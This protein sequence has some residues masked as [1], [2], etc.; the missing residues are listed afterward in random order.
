MAKRSNGEGSIYRRQDGRWCGS[1]YIETIDGVKR[2]YVYASTQKLVKQKLKELESNQEKCWEKVLLFQDWMMQWMESYKKPML[3]QTTYDN[4]MM[5]I[6]KHINGQSLGK[7]ELDKLTTDALQKFYNSKLVGDENGSKLSPRTI[8]YIHTIIGSSLKQAYKNELISKNVNDFT[9]LPR[10]EQ[11]EIEPLSI[12]EVRKLIEYVKDKEMYA[13]I[14]LEIYTGMRKGEI[15]SLQWKNVDFANKVLYVK[16]NLCRIK[17]NGE[18]KIEYV[19]MEPKTKKSIRKIPLCEEAIKALQIHKLRQEE[20]KIEY[21]DIYV[22]KDMV[23]A[24]KDGS[25]EDPREVLRRFHIMLERAGI[26]KCRFHDMRHT[27]A[28][29]L[30]NSGES[31]KVVQELLGHS[32]ITTTMDIYSHISEDT[33]EQTMSRLE[34]IVKTTK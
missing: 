6:N 29:I 17:G 4:Y 24:R 9:V 18:R 7:T 28:S 8:E 14:V 27:F 21:A 23:F 32:T 31:M 33:K 11:E 30:I 3:K 2:K 20:I 25:Y 1:I 16:N 15:L 22:D 34:S 26:R 13:L 5:N 12:E 10:Q 19:L